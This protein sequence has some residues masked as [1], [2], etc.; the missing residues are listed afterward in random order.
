M[1]IC[2]AADKEKASHSHSHAENDC[3]HLF[4]FFRFFFFPL[5]RDSGLHGA[6]ME[7]VACTIISNYLRGFKIALLGSGRANK[8]FALPKLLFCSPHGVLKCPFVKFVA[9][10][11][12]L[13]RL[14]L[15]SFKLI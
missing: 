12:P 5:V 15:V 13:G 9:V 2:N 7:V 4:F 6:V 1:F 8:G 14:S 10:S 11:C 3:Y